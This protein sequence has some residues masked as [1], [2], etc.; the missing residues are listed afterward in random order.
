MF[1]KN[2]FKKALI[3]GTSLLSMNVFANPSPTL[4]AKMSKIGTI[5][6]VVPTESKG[7]Y[8]WIYEKNGKTLVLYNTSD[9]K[10]FIKGTIYDLDTKKVVSNKY[11]ESSLKY[12]STEFKN[13]VLSQRSNT[14]TYPTTQGD[15]SKVVT[16]GGLASSNLSSKGVMNLKWKGHE[17]PQALKML[18]SLSGTKQGNGAPQ[19]TLYVFYDPRCPW[20]HR[21]FT[22]LQ[23]YVKKQYTVKWIPTVALGKTDEALKLA[24]APLQ[25]PNLLNA[26]FEKENSAKNITPTAEN[27]KS[28]NYNLQYLVAYF[29]AVEPNQAVSVP[30]GI[31]LD[32]STGKL[33]HVQGLTEKPILDLVFGNQ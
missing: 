21:T 5:K 8:A 3:L 11:V 32:K 16:S 9:E 31:M 26:S 17:I 12:S 7:V 19:D 28:L 23:P 18:N 2:M 13:K 1:S 4:K 25:N 15:V 27:I 30:F 29:K 10:Y 24:S 6:E 20:C 22:T 33:T 14:N